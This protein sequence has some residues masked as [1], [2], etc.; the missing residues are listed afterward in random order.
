METENIKYQ[1]RPGEIAEGLLKILYDCHHAIESQ[2]LDPSGPIKDANDEL[3][4]RILECAV[5][6]EFTSVF[7]YL[8]KQKW[9]ETVTLTK[10]SATATMLTYLQ[11]VR[12]KWDGMIHFARGRES[13]RFPGYELKCMD[14][15]RMTFES[16]PHTAE[17][18]ISDLRKIM[19]TFQ[20]SVVIITFFKDGPM[21]VPEPGEE[22]HLSCWH[23]EPDEK[24]GVMIKW[25]LK[26]GEGYTFVKE[27][28]LEKV[29]ELLS[30]GVRKVAIFDYHGPKSEQW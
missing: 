15:G 7:D 19:E 12:E 3:E 22:N 25:A 28:I 26:D 1:L 10:E 30:S 14:S 23:E 8:F 21:I 9:R 11:G 17:D 5:P 6:R 29:Q 20:P 27:N 4:R 13:R 2:G 16:Y 24:E 18:V